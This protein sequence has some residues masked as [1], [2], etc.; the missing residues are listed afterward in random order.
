MQLDVTARALVAVACLAALFGLCVAYG[1][2]YDDRWPHPTAEQLDEE[3][4]AHT[5]DGVLLFGEVRSIDTDDEELTIAVETD[6]G[7]IAAVIDVDDVP[8]GTVREGGT[9]QVY[10]T[11]ED[12][13]TM[14]AERFVVV[15]A[16]PAAER[17]KLGV[18]AIG[19]VFGIALFVRQWRPSLRTLSWEGRDG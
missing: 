1:A 16:G 6:D 4:D 11:L 5:G 2:T 13:R 7:S 10:G 8:E 14:G 9:L 19:L 17:Y 3:F 18:S 15:E 12:D